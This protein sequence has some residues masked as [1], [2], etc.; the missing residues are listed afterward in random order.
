MGLGDI[1]DVSLN[2]L[3]KSSQQ[4][5]SVADSTFIKNLLIILVKLTKLESA[6][7]L[8]SKPRIKLLCG[9]SLGFRLV[10]AKQL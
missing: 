7:F 2:K 4:R 3:A 6:Q 1:F 10:A 8:E 9:I 5:L